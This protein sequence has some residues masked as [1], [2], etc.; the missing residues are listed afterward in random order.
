MAFSKR[1]T[2]HLPT[3]P[4]GWSFQLGPG[5]QWGGSFS[6]VPP[7]LGNKIV[8]I[9]Y[10]HKR[11]CNRKLGFFENFCLFGVWR[12]LFGKAWLNKL[13]W[14]KVCWNLVWFF[15]G[16]S[17]NMFFFGDF[18]EVAMSNQM[19]VIRSPNISLAYS[20]IHPWSFC[21]DSIDV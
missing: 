3:S 13:I 8:K 12:Y 21:Q 19:Q 5:L 16:G 6:S 9:I 15:L 14:W 2:N 17:G 4:T 7:S 20:L 1:V 10:K 11:N 18:V